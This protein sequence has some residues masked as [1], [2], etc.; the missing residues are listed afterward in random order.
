MARI[1]FLG[2]G[3]IATALVETLAGK[4]HKIFVSERNVTVSSGLAARFS[5]VTVAP[6]DQV[7][8][9]SEVVFLCLLAPVAKAVLPDLPFRADHA[10]VSRHGRSGP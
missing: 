2:T 8:A 9:Q 10:I 6:N 1:G 3:E 4:G 7:V 5:D